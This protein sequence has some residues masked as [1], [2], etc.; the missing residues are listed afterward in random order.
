MEYNRMEDQ[1][2]HTLY[3]MDSLEN[4]NDY[5][6]ERS[7]KFPNGAAVYTTHQTNGR[8]SHGRRWTAP[9]GEALFMSLLYKNIHPQ[10]L[11]V[12]PLVCGVAVMHMLDQNCPY[13]AKIKWPNDVLLDGKKVCGIL[14]E[15]VVEGSR[16][17]VV[18]GIGVNLR[19]TRET[20]DRME[21]FDAG[22][23]LSQAGTVRSAKEVAESLLRHMKNVWEEWV[24]YGFSGRLLREYRSRCLTLNRPVILWQNHVPRQA[25]AE[26][27]LPDG[28][29]ICSDSAG[30]FAVASGEASVRTPDGY[31]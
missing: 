17:D 28:R 3:Y 27:V 24:R 23:L 25:Y 2:N 16:A 1:A 5:M 7:A 4:T 9:R 22:S 6:R 20:F 21:L 8:G 14:C 18:C 29:L 30:R 26:G 10:H 12:L 19:T 31:S 15:S 13:Q 11:S